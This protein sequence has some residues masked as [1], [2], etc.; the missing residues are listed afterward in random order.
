MPMKACWPKR[1]RALIIGL[2]VMLVLVAAVYA[3]AYVQA[4][5]HFQDGRIYCHHRLYNLSAASAADDDLK[6]LLRDVRPTG[7]D[8]FGEEV[9]DLPQST[10]TS[11]VILLKSKDGTFHVYGLSGGP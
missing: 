3:L 5:R 4:W 6:P 8:I 11:T 1:R 7:T 2:G 10:K 9:Y